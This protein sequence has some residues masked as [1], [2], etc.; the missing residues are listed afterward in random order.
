MKYLLKSL[1][2]KVDNSEFAVKN[3]PFYLF[4]FYLKSVQV[5]GK[6]VPSPALPWQA[7]ESWLQTLYSSASRKKIHLILRVFVDIIDFSYFEF[8]KSVI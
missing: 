7:S 5:A 2:L 6:R 1:L 4:Y 8:F 3:L